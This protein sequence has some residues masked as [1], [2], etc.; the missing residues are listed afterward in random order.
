MKPITH[1]D[2]HGDT[3]AFTRHHRASVVAEVNNSTAVITPL[4]VLAEVLEAHGYTCTHTLPP[5]PLS[6]GDMIRVPDDSYSYSDEKVMTP[7]DSN[8]AVCARYTCETTGRSFNVLR[9][10]SNSHVHADGAEILWS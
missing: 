8:G 2:S 3:I 9:S 1:T 5:R 10:S 6:V 7:P 4:S